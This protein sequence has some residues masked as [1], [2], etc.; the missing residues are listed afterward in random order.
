LNCKALEKKFLKSEA[1]YLKVVDRMQGMQTEL[2][3]AQNELVEIHTQGGISLLPQCEEDV[4]NAKML[5]IKHPDKVMQRLNFLMAEFSFIMDIFDF[6]NGDP[7]YQ[8]MVQQHLEQM[9][10]IA[11]SRKLLQHLVQ[12]QQ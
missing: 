4:V 5:S 8:G 12:Q 3:L 7:K 11:G 2:E 10:D 1:K 9:I 6:E